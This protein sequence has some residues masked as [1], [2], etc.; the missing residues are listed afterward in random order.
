L[1]RQLKASIV[2]AL[3]DERVSFAKD[4]IKYGSGVL[5]G[6]AAI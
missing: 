5:H 3:P 6:H 1:A 2:Q 4:L